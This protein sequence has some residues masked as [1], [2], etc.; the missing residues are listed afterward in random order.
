M[1]PSLCSIHLIGLLMIHLYRY[2]YRA[3]R[4]RY[5][6]SNQKDDVLE[7]VACNKVYTSLGINFYCQELCGLFWC[8][9]FGLTIYMHMFC[10]AKSVRKRHDCIKLSNFNYVI[11]S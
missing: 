10:S 5:E 2:L 11:G 1:I 3:C 7:A 4:E 8:I 9:M 6:A